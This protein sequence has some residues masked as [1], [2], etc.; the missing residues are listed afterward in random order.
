[1]KHCGFLDFTVL[2]LNAR[3]SCGKS[4]FIILFIIYCLFWLN[5]SFKTYKQNTNRHFVLLVLLLSFVL[6]VEKKE[7]SV[8]AK[9]GWGPTHTSA[10][11][12]VYERDSPAVVVG[13]SVVLNVPQTAGSW[14]YRVPN[15][16][17]PLFFSFLPLPLLHS[18]PLSSSPSVSRFVVT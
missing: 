15:A 5:Y 16:P 1:M 3:I 14:Y 18:P 13:P 17:S 2:F 7:S 12:C 4:E 6:I 9:F 11:A 10:R 8:T